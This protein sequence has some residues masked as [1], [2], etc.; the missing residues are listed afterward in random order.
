MKATYLSA[1]LAAGLFCLAAEAGPPPQAPPIPRPGVRE[2]DGPAPMPRA[3]LPAAPK[4]EPKA[5]PK[6]CPH[7]GPECSCGPGCDC[8]A[9]TWRA[10][11]KAHPANGGRG[12]CDADGC[13]PR[14]PAAAPVV[15]VVPPAYLPPPVYY[16]PPAPPR[17]GIRFGAGFQFGAGGGPAYCP[18]GGT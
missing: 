2:S 9:E 1:V 14:P 7:C 16:F 15:P 17:G 13:R 8:N 10:D 6:G 4:A 18:P 11:C 3:A 5:A 12:P